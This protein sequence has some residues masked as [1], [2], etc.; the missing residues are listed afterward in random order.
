ME[1]RAAVELSAAVEPSAAVD[2]AAAVEQSVAWRALLVR[3]CYKVPRFMYRCGSLVYLKVNT[4]LV[5]G[6]VPAGFLFK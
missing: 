2:R 3:L 5:K 4:H 1:L 6:L